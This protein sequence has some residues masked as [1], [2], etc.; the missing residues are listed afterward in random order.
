[1]KIV[2][3]LS[4][5]CLVFFIC[6]TAAARVVPLGEELFG[7]DK[8]EIEFEVKPSDVFTIVSSSYLSGTLEIRARDSETAG[9]TFQKIAKVKSRGKAIEYLDK[10]IVDVHQMADG[11]SLIFQAPNP[12]PW[13]ETNDDVRVEGILYLPESLT[14]DINASYFDLVVEGPFSSFTNKSSFGKIDIENITEKLDITTTGRNLNLTDIHGDISV[15]S[16]STNLKIKEMSATSKTAQIKNK[17]GD[18]YIDEARGSF[19]IM[20]SYGKIRLSNMIFSENRSDI[21]GDYCSLD[22]EIKEI[23]TS[24]LYIDNSFEDIN[25][26]VPQ[27]ISAMFDIYTELDGEIHVTGIPFIAETVRSSHVKLKAGNGESK[28]SVDNEGGRDI[29]VEGI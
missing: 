10:V 28:I 29:I 4:L 17:S 14:V 21:D 13:A 20:N 18:I 5:I 12:A 26:T 7:S 24:S 9:F 3:Y 19:N 25:L 2:I 15:N 16:K 23:N 22:I 11:M 27:S 6:S 1:M 8:E